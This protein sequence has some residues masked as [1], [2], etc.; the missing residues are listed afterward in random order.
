MPNIP[1][2][3]DPREALTISVMKLIHPVAS[4]YD[5]SEANMKAQWYNNPGFRHSVESVV[6]FIESKTLY[7]EE[8]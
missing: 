3:L 2:T 5:L 4:P 8:K 7:A 6:S 1:A